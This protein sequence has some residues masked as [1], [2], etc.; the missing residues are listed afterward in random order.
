MSKPTVTSVQ[1]HIDRHEAVC[2][3][4]WKETILRIKRIEHIMIGTAGTIIVLLLGIIIN[5][6]N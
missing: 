3:E 5:G 2:T 6:T 4:R 1:A